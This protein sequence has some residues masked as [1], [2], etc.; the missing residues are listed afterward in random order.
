MKTIKHYCK[1]TAYIGL[2]AVTLI[3]ARPARADVYWGGVIDTNWANLAN[4]GFD[5]TVDTVGNPATANGNIIIN[6]GNNPCVVFTPGNSSSHD[7][8]ISVG[9]GLTIL[10]GGQLTNGGNFITGQFGNSLPVNVSGQQTVD[11]YL[12]LGNGGYAGSMNIFSGGSV[13]SAHLSINSTG[14]AQLNV[15]TNG[16]YTTQFSDLGNVNYWIANN[17]IVANGNAPGWAIDV[18][19]NIYPGFVLLTAVY[20]PPTAGTNFVFNNGGGDEIWTN[21]LNWSPVGIPGQYDTANVANDLSVILDSG[22]EGF[23]NDLLVG[24]ASK[25]GAVNFETNCSVSFRSNTISLLVAGS[26]NNDTRPSSCIFTGGSVAT[27]GDLVLGGSGGWVDARHYGGICTV[28][29]TLRLGS[30]LYPSGAS[31]TN[32]SLRLI[33]GSGSIGAGAVELG[34][35]GTLSYEFNGGSSV[36]TLS[37][38]GTVD[39]LP[40]AVLKIDGTGYSGL[41]SYFTLLQGASVTG[42]FGATIFTNFPNGVTPSLNYN[43]ANVTLSLVASQPNFGLKAINLG[44]GT[45]QVSWNFGNIETA[46][47]V[48][49][50]WQLNQCAASPLIQVRSSGNQFY[51]GV[52][53]G[54][55]RSF[56]N[57]S[58]DNLWTTA[59]NWN[60]NG[61]PG[62]TDD[63]LI[64]GGK[65][66]Y[67]LEGAGTA[68]S[69][70]V[71]D[72][73]GN[74]A[75]NMNPGGAI[76]FSNPCQSVVIGGAFS[77]PNN[78]ASYYR[79]SNANLYTAGDFV[80]GRNG[81]EA[82]A[83]FAGPGVLSVGGTFRLGS[84]SAGYSF[85]NI[86]GNAG[87]GSLTAG[88]FEVG[89][90]GELQYYFS[91]GSSLLTI[92]VNGFVNLLPGS[93]L[94]IDGTGYPNV[95]GTYN[96]TLIQ[97]GSTSG[98][99]TTVNVNNFPVAGTTATVS[100]S[101]GNVALQVVVP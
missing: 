49:G 79:H 44:H 60:P 65:G 3:F 84:L 18:N 57:A 17:A 8:Y 82:N 22:T 30:Y 29:G 61:T 70:T 89:S 23:V 21:I 78:Y 14:G 35:A 90:E 101:G 10:S 43:A 100:Y 25:A 45:N 31:P 93:T 59:L 36:K 97:G 7:C 92:T 98:T 38:I 77:S 12:L 81:G 71:G 52:L 85:F 66:A 56:L 32:A 64:T 28:G 39:I 69:V 68:G 42:T 13:Q 95:A 91:S 83:Q 15:S 2:L 54:T 37:A 46:Q 76:N 80:L 26:S 16:S 6:A 9:V 94:T 72:A 51:R 11:G 27:V 20:T 87:G 53:L 88:N 40:G 1:A 55:P 62:P 67:V 33:G 48:S 73:A 86:P 96:Y 19:T 47:S 99:F 24:N 58:G 50:P 74:G 41:S 5:G 34:S 4:W 63:V 75:F